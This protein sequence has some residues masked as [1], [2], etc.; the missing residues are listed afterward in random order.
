MK[1]SAET[2]WDFSTET[3][4]EKHKAIMCPKILNYATP[5]WFIQVYS[6]HLD[7]LEVI[8]N[9]DLRPEKR[10]KAVVSNLRDEIGVLPLRA[11]LELSSQQFYKS[12]LQSIHPSHLQY[13]CVFCVHSG[14]HSRPRCTEA[15]QVKGWSLPVT[16]PQIYFNSFLS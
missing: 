9:K 16:P 2:S 14:Q 5:I 10:K 7:K 8:Q 3:L 15:L 6:S 12:V 11:Q 1:A 4:V 13:Y